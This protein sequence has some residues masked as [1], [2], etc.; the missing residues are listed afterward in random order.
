ML[1]QLHDCRTCPKTDPRFKQLVARVTQNFDTFEDYGSNLD[2][3]G[4]QRV[5]KTS[6]DHFYN[7]DYR[8]V[9]KPRIPLPNL[10]DATS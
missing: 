4:K 9:R 7:Y 1:T 6:L 10:T 3:V 8:R 5:Q 2:R